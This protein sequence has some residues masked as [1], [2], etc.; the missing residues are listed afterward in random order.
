MLSTEEG[1]FLSNLLTQHDKTSDLISHFKT[2]YPTRTADEICSQ[3]Y[4]IR[5][6]QAKARLERRTEPPPTKPRKTAVW[7]DVGKEKYDYNTV[8]EILAKTEATTG[9]LRQAYY[10]RTGMEIPLRTL[11]Y[12]LRRLRN[13]D[14]ICMH[15]VSWGRRGRTK[16]ISVKQKEASP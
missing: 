6:A 13:A 3:L 9:S 2:S 1:N 5:L 15:V 10:E 4:L 11:N 14:R 12:G 7:H 16:V 8:L